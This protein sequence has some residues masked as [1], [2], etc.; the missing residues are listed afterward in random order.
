MPNIK[1]VILSRGADTPLTPKNKFATSHTSILDQ[2]V[3]NKLL[4]NLAKNKIGDINIT[5]GNL[6]AYTELRAENQSGWDMIGNALAQTAGEIVGGGIEGIGNII[7]LIHKPFDNDPWFERNA[8]ESLGS[9]IM[10]WTRETF[11]IYQSKLA[12]QGSFIERMSHFSSW[13][14]LIPSALGSAVSIM[15]P[16]AIAS[17]GLAT[18]AKVAMKGLSKSKKAATLF[19]L[20]TD[21][22]KVTAATRIDKFSQIYLS[23]LTSRYLDSSREAANKYIEA[24][25]WFNDNYKSFAKQDA[26]GEYILK[27]DGSKLYLNNSSDVALA[28]EEYAN[29]VAAKGFRRSAA[30]IVFDII[31]WTGIMNAARTFNRKSIAQLKDTFTD[32]LGS[33]ASTNMI[34]QFS[35]NNK[36]AIGKNL[37]LQGAGAIG[38]ALDEAVMSLAMSEGEYVA[39]RQYG[40]LR[41]SEIMDWTDRQIKN[42]M[43]SDTLIEALGGFLGGTFMETVLPTTMRKIFKSEIDNEARYIENLKRAISNS[44]AGFDEVSKLLKDGEMVAANIRMNELVS[45]VIGNGVTDG[46]IDFL[47]EMLESFDSEVQR[48]N[49]LKKRKDRGEAISE[50][51]NK[52]IEAA[53]AYLN[54]PDAIRKLINKINLVK[55]IYEEESDSVPVSKNPIENLANHSIA[56]QKAEIRAKIRLYEEEMA[57]DTLNKEEVYKL[58][59]EELRNSNIPEDQINEAEGYVRTLISIAAKKEQTKIMKKVRDSRA[60]KLDEAQSKLDSE[61][62]STAKANLGIEV[63]RRKDE[64]KKD[65]ELIAKHENEIKILEDSLGNTTLSSD[66]GK[67]L[68]SK[69][70][71]LITL[72]KSKVDMTGVSA[73][74]EADIKF[75]KNQLASLGT[76]EYKEAVISATERHI[77]GLDSKIDA[78]FKAKVVKIDDIDALKDLASKETNEKNKKFINARIKELEAEKNLNEYRAKA[79]AIEE[80]NRTRNDRNLRD[81]NESDDRFIYSQ[82]QAKKSNIPSDLLNIYNQVV[83]EGTHDNRA[84]RIEESLNRYSKLLSDRNEKLTGA[85]RDKIKSELV[86]YLSELDSILSNADTPITI[87]DYIANAIK[88]K[89]AKLNL[90]DDEINEIVNKLDL[91]DDATID[92]ALAMLNLKLEAIESIVGIASIEETKKLIIDSFRE[93][94]NRTD[95]IKTRLADSIKNGETLYIK[96]GDAVYKI[97]KIDLTN[98]KITISTENAADLELSISELHQ[99]GLYTDNTFIL[100]NEAQALSYSQFKS[101]PNTNNPDPAKS[102]ANTQTSGDLQSTV[103]TAFKEAAIE[104]DSDDHSYTV[105]DENGERKKANLTP[106]RIDSNSNSSSELNTTTKVGILSDELFRE[107]FT[108]PV[109]DFKIHGRDV[110]ANLLNSARQIVET[111]K[112]Q[113]Q[114]IVNPDGTHNLVYITKETAVAAYYKNSNNDEGIIAGTPDLIVYDTTENK[115]YIFDFKTSKNPKDQKAKTEKGVNKYVKQVSAY[116]YIINSIFTDKGGF[117][118]GDVIGGTIHIGVKYDETDTY[119]TINDIAFT[120][121]VEDIH[122]IKYNEEYDNLSRPIVSTVNRE[123]LQPAALD[124]SFLPT[125]SQIVP[126]DT[127]IDEGHDTQQTPSGEE[128]DSGP[129]DN[130]P[131]IQGT[132]NSQ[133]DDAVFQAVALLENDST[134]EEYLKTVGVWLDENISM[135]DD[136]KKEIETSITMIANLIKVLSNYSGVS[137]SSYTIF[138]LIDAL[139]LLKGDNYIDNI[140][141]SAVSLHIAMKAVKE[142]TK[143]TLVIL[144][145]VFVNT[146]D[147]KARE[148]LQKKIIAYDKINKLINDSVKL[149]IITSSEVREYISNNPLRLTSNANSGLNITLEPDGDTDTNMLK[150]QTVTGYNQAKPYRTLSNLSAGDE[151]YLELSNN[152]R[153]VNESTFKI[154]KKVG[155][156]KVYLGILNALNCYEN[157]VQYLIRSKNGVYRFRDFT[158]IISDKHGLIF[159]TISDHYG[160]LAKFY[161]SWIISTEKLNNVSEDAIDEANRYVKNFI[162]SL[163]GIETNKNTVLKKVILEVMFDGLTDDQIASNPDRGESESIEAFKN[164]I[165]GEQ[166]FG[167][168]SDMFYMTRLSDLNRPKPMSASLIR[169]KFYKSIKVKET[170]FNLNKSLRNEIAIASKDGS[171]ADKPFVIGNVMGSGVIVNDEH[172]Y[173]EVKDSLS[174]V[175]F[176][177]KAYECIGIMHNRNKL[178]TSIRHVKETNSGGT[179]LTGANEGKDPFIFRVNADGVPYNVKTGTILSEDVVRKLNIPKYGSILIGKRNGLFVVVPV[180]DDTYTVFPVKNNSIIG[181]LEGTRA[182]REES[183]RKYKDYISNTI[184]EFSDNLSL[185]TLDNDDE[186]NKATIGSLIDETVDRLKDVIIA[187]KNSS[188]NPYF[189]ITYTGNGTLEITIAR[190]LGTQGSGSYA[191]TK[192]KI[193]NSNGEFRFIKIDSTNNKDFE[194]NITSNTIGEPISALSS[195]IR[196]MTEYL[197]RSFNFDS[198][199]KVTTANGADNNFIDPVTGT[200]YDNFYQY[201]MMTNAVYSDVG[202]VRSETGEILSNVGFGTTMSPKFSIMPK[203]IYNEGTKAYT[204]PRDILRITGITTKDLQMYSAVS[205]MNDLLIELG[206]APYYTLNYDDFNGKPYP[207]YGKTKLYNYNPRVRSVIPGYAPNRF[208]ITINY[209]PAYVNKHNNHRYIGRTLIHEMLHTVLIKQFNP[210]NNEQDIA[211]KRVLIDYNNALFDQF[212]NALRKAYDAYINKTDGK[213]ET[214]DGESL[215]TRDLEYLKG[216]LK[217]IEDNRDTVF[218]NIRNKLANGINLN[219]NDTIQDV[220]A[221]AFTDEQLFIVL[222]KL[223]ALEGIDVAKSTEHKSIWHQIKALLLDILKTIFGEKLI[224]NNNTVMSQVD[225]IITSVFD[226]KIEDIKASPVTRGIYDIS[227]SSEDPGRED[228]VD[229]SG[230]SQS[231]A[232]GSE[233]NTVTTTNPD[234][235]PDVLA[236]SVETS[237]SEKQSDE[238]EIPSTESGFISRSSDEESDYS[239]DFQLAISLENLFDN[240][241]E[242]AILD[243]TN[244]ILC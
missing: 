95:E 231:S 194:F 205:S 52:E 14:T 165:S 113:I 29:G 182:E 162:K 89:F 102:V 100:L 33:T 46:S 118:K 9:G 176:N 173:K 67:E 101:V 178:L 94:Q 62:D 234:N 145:K 83:I 116:S 23:A 103:E 140:A 195:D 168:L 136:I 235:T 138:D 18:A 126:E 104:F 230:T 26:N 2:G 79:A 236:G 65:D 201:L 238:Q 221:H 217:A 212:I 233:T 17:K 208:G 85:D 189:D 155:S 132:Q 57:N 179:V 110:N 93:I 215:T 203:D 232:N 76:K 30:N 135:I 78:D 150:N 197:T 142:Q 196:N 59:N 227:K 70:D 183:L 222:N 111:I 27:E 180:S 43:D 84:D 11:P 82:A 25:Q 87:K 151:I 137:N 112:S 42:L 220:I 105:V 192:Y 48:I 75:L 228:D 41:E 134:N 199:N 122:V 71:S 40:L 214:I 50:E 190:Y 159:K 171:L 124:H 177:G 13:A 77:E 117:S 147:A 98:G 16:A 54:D 148:E 97:E 24:K 74:F 106:S 229:G 166:L 99:D 241:A 157:A 129:S 186:V 51:E 92:E 49:D 61:T 156:D 130:T 139:R 32:N 38:E 123:T 64:L 120:F 53:A 143:A 219:G 107:I 226:A 187:S 63:T 80:A 86:S 133:Q 60:N 109:D 72:Y 242:N 12:Q 3:N 181:S 6:E 81:V 37:A 56:M 127:S 125:G 39:K 96:M 191:Y 211:D 198:S 141:E 213:L 206:I 73:V 66:V 10:D 21:I 225:D 224:I 45:E 239:D 28:A 69:K 121:D 163:N 193:F 200:Q 34:R 170:V 114:K 164:R 210:S 240:L 144:N 88:T 153:S 7:G 149:D 8:I 31:Q 152:S 184:S 172:S 119:P 55:P 108:H 207:V 35:R 216:F 5:P 167:V 158:G 244:K 15:L 202:Y 169:D 204:D 91:T 175:M 4:T 174:K 237:E 209:D 243:D 47:L 68:N 1:D 223:K 161:K 128:H 188:Y 58:I 185:V 154:Y 19:K 146:N 90:T 115:V 20:S 22:N 218:N 36:I 44:K 160:E 131:K